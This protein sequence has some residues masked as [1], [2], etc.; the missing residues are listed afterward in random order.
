VQKKFAMIGST[1]TR[2]C[3]L[4]T[5]TCLKTSSARFSGLSYVQLQRLRE[6]SIRRWTK[7]EIA[8]PCFLP[9][10]SVR[11]ASSNVQESVPPNGNGNGNG[12][13]KKEVIYEELVELI[14]KGDIRLVDVREP[15]ELQETGQ[16]P[17]SIN[18]PLKQLKSFLQQK[19]DAVDSEVRNIPCPQKDDA[20]LIYY[21]LSEVKGLAALEIAH[22]CGYK[23][24]RHYPG[25]WD[26]WSKKQKKT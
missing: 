2:T 21:G 5:G 24:S 11:L 17:K 10:S 8:I 3:L 13:K 20:N 6:I 1:V 7:S 16:I 12:S 26:E 22:K 18:I 14:E 4:V 9:T 25:G 15:K 19:D 23:K